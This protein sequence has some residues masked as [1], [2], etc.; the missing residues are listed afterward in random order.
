MQQ[1][2]RISMAVALAVLSVS[3]PAFAA[4]GHGPPEADWGRLISA[5]VNFTVY[6]GL[7]AYFFGGKIQGAFRSRR[8]RL[9]QAIDAAAEARTLAEATLAEAKGKA[10]ALANDREAVVREARE[11]GERDRTRI[12]ELAKAQAAKIASDAQA[13]ASAAER[14]AAHALRQQLVD[15]A[16]EL[17]RADLEKQMDAAAHGRALDESIARVVAAAGAPAA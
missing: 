6:V 17:A 8:D 11:A 5:I 15:R 9:M 16:L 1:S 13:Q 10:A 2:I 14:R 4:D 3:A 12:V 7:I